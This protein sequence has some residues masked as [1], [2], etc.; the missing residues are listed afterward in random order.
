MAIRSAGQSLQRISEIY[1]ML[2]LSGKSIETFRSSHFRVSRLQKVTEGRIIG[3][4]GKDTKISEV[5]SEYT[6][7]MHH[8]AVEGKLLGTAYK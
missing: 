7:K 1:D 4:S 2:F 8:E 6:S 5:T 3:C